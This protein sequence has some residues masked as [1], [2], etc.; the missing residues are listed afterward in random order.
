MSALVKDLFSLGCFS[1]FANTIRFEHNYAEYLLTR[2]ENSTR[3]PN[4]PSESPASEM[5]QALALF[6]VAALLLVHHVDS[7]A[8]AQVR[9]AISSPG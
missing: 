4:Q 8:I 6:V 5:R 9:P 1:Y 2:R 3:D 7:A